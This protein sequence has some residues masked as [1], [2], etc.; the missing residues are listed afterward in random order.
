MTR[1]RQIP[2]CATRTRTRAAFL[3][4][5][6]ILLGGALGVLAFRVQHA[7]PPWGRPLVASAAGVGLDCFALFATAAFAAIL[8]KRAQG[9]TRWFAP[10]LMLLSTLRESSA[11]V[12]HPS[13]ALLSILGL[14]LLVHACARRK[15]ALAIASIV[16]CAGLSIGLRLESARE[17]AQGM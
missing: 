15:L 2:A 1:A 5:G 6:S 11:M 8:T 13:L 7:T 16:I 3:V 17:P 12:G 9:S 14:C 10:G 4:A